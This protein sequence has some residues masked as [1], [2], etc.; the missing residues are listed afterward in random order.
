MQLAD[1]TN[2]HGEDRRAAV[3]ALV[4]VD[5]GDDGVA[6]V[7]GLDRLGDAFGSS[8]SSGA[9]RPVLMSQK[10]HERVQMSPIIRK[11]AVPAPQHSPMFG[12]MASSHTVCSVLLRIIWRS[13]SKVSP[14]GARTR[15]HSGRR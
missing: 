5:A 10:P 9:G 8:Q 12:H 6:Q 11:V 4:A 15:I 14:D 7:H 1:A 3:L 2:D 13:H